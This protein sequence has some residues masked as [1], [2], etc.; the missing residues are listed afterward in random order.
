MGS[1]DGEAERGNN[2]E[3]DRHPRAAGAADGY[4]RRRGPDEPGKRSG[5][6]QHWRR[7]L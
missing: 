4:S 2:E 3:H 1:E 6:R 7:R 5:D